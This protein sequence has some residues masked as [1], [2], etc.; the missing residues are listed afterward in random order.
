MIHAVGATIGRPYIKY[1][2][3]SI[4]VKIKE[5]I[6][7]AKQPN[8]IIPIMLVKFNTISFT[9]FISN[10]LAGFFIGFIAI[11]GYVLVLVSFIFKDL[12]KCGFLIY[13]LI[14]KVF[15]YLIEFCSKIPLSQIS[16]KT[17]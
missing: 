17:Q 12:A 11:C 15:L 16:V 10:I 8:I 2:L 7:R 4:Y 3:H 9:F 14:L 5:N 1:L 6:T 13:N